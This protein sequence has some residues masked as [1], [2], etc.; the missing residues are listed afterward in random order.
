MLDYKVYE[1][2]LEDFEKLMIRNQN[3][4][5]V[6]IGSDQWTLKEIVGHLI[7]SASNNH[8]RFVRLQIDKN[9]IPSI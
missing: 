8:E 9:Y 5:E 6:K 1:K 4:S 2:M 7:D 3:I